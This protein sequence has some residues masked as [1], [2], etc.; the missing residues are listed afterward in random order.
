MVNPND[1]FT[2]HPKFESTSADLNRTL[3][4]LE[5]ILYYPEEYTNERVVNILHSVVDD[6]REAIRTLRE[7]IK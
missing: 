2:G 5:S 3:S 6:I 4:D 1:T 7:S